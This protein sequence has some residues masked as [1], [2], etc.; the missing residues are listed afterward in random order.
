M[1][2][3]ARGCAILEAFDTPARVG[4]CRADDVLAGRA[5]KDWG[6]VGTPSG[7]TSPDRDAATGVGESDSLGGP[8]TAAG[9]E[10]PPETH[11]RGG[12][13]RH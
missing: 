2:A 8:A 4:T 11:T 12:C 1:R 5:L 7:W 10:Q 9:D 3:G 13:R 6:G